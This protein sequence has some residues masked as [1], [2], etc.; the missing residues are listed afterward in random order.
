LAGGR[1]I[2]DSM[3]DP[4][5]TETVPTL[6]FPGRQRELPLG[7]VISGRYEIHGFLGRGGHGAVYRVLDREIRREIALK[8]LDPDRESPSALARLRREVQVARDATNPHLVKIFDIG[9]SPQGTYLTME[10]VEGS[11][12]RELLRQGPLSIDE[13][14]RISI[15]LFEGLA[16][17]HGLAI[18]HRDVKP[19]NILMAGRREAKLADFGL[20]RRLDREETQ[21][22]RTE[23][24]VGTL[25]YLS[26][27][28]ALGKEAG[29]ESDLYSA[30]LVLFEM[31]T[32]R[33]PHEAV[34]YLGRRLGQFQRAPN[35]RTLRP[36]VPR[37]L[38]RVIDRLLE[39][40]LRD[41]YSSAQEVL[42]DLRRH[43]GPPRV[44]LWRLLLRAAFVA[45]LFLPQ[46]GIIVRRVPETTFSHLVPQGE[47]GIAAVSATGEILW[48]KDGVDPEMADRAAFTRITP[49][50]P[51]LIAIVLA[52]PEDW[53]PDAVA[54]LSFLA[55]ETGE[56][57]KEVKLPTRTGANLFPNDPPRFMPYSVQALDL[58]HD[59]VDEVLVSYHHVPESPSFTILYA[60][61][62]ERARIVFYTRGGLGFQGATD[63]D[64]DGFLDLLFAG[65]SNGW[66]WV[67]AVAAVRLDRWPWTD[68]NWRASPTA[69][70][71]VAESL[72]EERRL[73]WYA[74]I[75]RGALESP[76]CLRINE[77]DRKLT[78]RYAAGNTWP[79][80]FDGFPWKAPDAPADTEREE[81]RRETYRHFREAERLRRAGA[82]DLAMSEAKAAFQSAEKAREPWLG[83]YAER[84]EAKLLVFLGKIPEAEGRFASLVERAE[85]APEVAY[86]AAVAFHLAGDLQRAASWYERGIGRDSAVGAGKSKHEFLKGEVL[87]LVEEKRYEEALRAVDRFDATYPSSHE[88]VWLYREYSRWRFGEHPV[89]DPSRISLRFTD[90]ER[91]WALEFQFASGGKPEALLPQVDR[92]LAE[93]PETRAEALSLR[94]ELLARLGRAIEAAEVA[95]SALELVRGEAGR[96]IIARGHADLLAARARRLADNARRPM[97]QDRTR[98]P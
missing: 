48:T 13:A 14:I 54:T 7:T 39:M 12:L 56:V 57:V 80:G 65:I 59:G 77:H 79:L 6:S 24:I 50:G 68:E 83:Q 74:V 73:L 5:R 46:T 72:L 19:G 94:A 86:D 58:F 61:R 4:D 53:L 10:L 8:L 82:L 3:L 32:G 41:R 69:P 90:L 33:L 70:P 17:L 43:H 28:Q 37:W 62:A 91:Y 60:P 20:A 93:R 49:G 75:P 40:R 16:A 23:G 45:L 27:E 63:L 11:S 42:V 21:V 51:R 64:G 44:R 2:S 89:V 35:L 66:N 87:A 55:P 92:F 85:D 96:S 97:P 38:A 34:S 1:A 18:V 31:L 98:I 78:A 36:E 9:T 15:Q 76:F 95:Q 22:T 84:L 25:D 81:A 67:N 52:P 88:K 71:D 47:R 30:G 29:R 26:P